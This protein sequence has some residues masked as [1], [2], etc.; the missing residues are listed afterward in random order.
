MNKLLDKIKKKLFKVGSIF[1]E[2]EPVK[3]TPKVAIIE[4]YDLEVDF[5]EK[6]AENAKLNGF[7]H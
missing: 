5:K 3:I 7:P 6:M 1:I 4:P 2:E